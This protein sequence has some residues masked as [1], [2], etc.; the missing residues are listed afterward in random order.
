LRTLRSIIPLFTLLT[1]CSGLGQAQSPATSNDTVIVMP[2]ENA[3]GAPGLEWISEA[4][5]EILTQR[6]SSPNVFVLTRDDRLR[7]YDRA[8]LPSD[9]HPTRA[10]MYRLV[11]EMDVDYVVFGLYAFDGRNFT[12]T[13]QLLD[14]Q[15]KRLLPESTESGALV[16]LISIQT[17]LAWDLLRILHPN[18]TATKQAFTAAAP[19]IRLDAFENYIRGIL[20]GTTVEKVSHFREATRLKPTYDEAW[21]RLGQTYFDNRQYDQAVSAFAEVSQ[22][23]PAAREANFYLGLAAY[24]LGDFSKAQ[25][26]FSFVSARLPLTEVDNNLG[27]VTSRLGDSKTAARHFQKA[28]QQ[29]PADA[30]YRFNLAVALYRSGDPSGAIRELQECLNLRPDD[31]E[32]KSMLALLSN[33]ARAG[34]FAGLKGSEVFLERV[35]RNYD[36]NSFRQLIVGIQSAAEERLANTDPNTHAQFYV[37]QGQE[38]LGKGFVGEAEKA[39]RQALA[40]TPSNAEAHAGLANAL[41]ANGD[42]AGARAEAEAALSIRIFVDPLLLLARLDLRDN[43]ADAAAQSVDQ[44]LKLDPAN[45]KALTLKRAV[46]AKLAEKAQPLPN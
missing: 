31:A 3:S 28:A 44:A 42:I 11:E 40:L 30:D 13:A 8:G 43:K 19:P 37:S 32:A 33:A 2:F 16:D 27:V 23:D 1:L 6:L 14:M 7:A 45:S 12:A 4:F 24:Y 35:K 39:F 38:L 46:A 22:S 5:P 18:L 17:S 26:A 21:L 15:H 20:A 29:D 10:T 34:G 25:S 36:E 41:E 9:V